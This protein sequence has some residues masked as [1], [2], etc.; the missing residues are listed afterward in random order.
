MSYREVAAS[1]LTLPCLQATYDLRRSLTPPIAYVQLS[2]K[3]ETEKRG[4]GGNFSTSKCFAT[5]KKENKSGNF[6]VTHQAPAK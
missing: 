3:Y 6:G 4:G 1:V 5:E 2:P